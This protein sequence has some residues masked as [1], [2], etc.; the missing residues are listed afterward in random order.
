MKDDI[1]P[2][3]YEAWR[4]CIEVDCGLQ[5][6]A[7][8]IRERIAALGDASDYHTQQ[9]VRRWGEPHR[10]RVVTWFLRA[11]KELDTRPSS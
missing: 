10:Q 7:S 11:G 3:S 6:N 4:Y 9:F 1:V 5:L 2:D 8:Y